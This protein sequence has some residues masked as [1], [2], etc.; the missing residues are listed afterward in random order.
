MVSL[1]IKQN[2]MNKTNSLNIK[3]ALNILAC[4]LLTV[5]Q[6]LKE[7]KD[8]FVKNILNIKTFN[9]SLSSKIIVVLLK[10]AVYKAIT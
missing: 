1:Y 6:T 2:T 3:I 8:L 5:K 7:I 9:L 4:R 10:Q